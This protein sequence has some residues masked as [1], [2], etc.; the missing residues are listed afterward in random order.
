MSNCSKFR[1]SQTFK[2]KVHLIHDAT[3]ES[4]IWDAL[5]RYPGVL[6]AN[7]KKKA[8]FTSACH[9]PVEKTDNTQ[10]QIKK[11]V[12]DTA[13]QTIDIDMTICINMVH[14]TSLYLSALIFKIILIT[15][16]DHDITAL[17]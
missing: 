13:M 9:L 3:K 5:V 6:A 15:H 17:L 4:I 7:M 16:I 2:E 12:P 8:L 1:K 10:T 14:L 11:K